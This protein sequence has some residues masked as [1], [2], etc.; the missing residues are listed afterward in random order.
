VRFVWDVF[1][2]WDEFCVCVY[3]YVCVCVSVCA[4]QAGKKVHFFGNSIWVKEE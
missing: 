4:Q 2:V 1:C 3:V